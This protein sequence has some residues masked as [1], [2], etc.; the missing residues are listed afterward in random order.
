MYY[1]FGVSD[2]TSRYLAA[3]FGILTVV[4]AMF[5]RPFLGRWGTFLATAMIVFSPSFMYFDR[6]CRED[7]YIAGATFLMA[8]FLFRYYR[9]RQPSDLWWA[10]IGF[11]IAFCTKESM[12]L[13]IAVFGTYLFIRLLPWADVLIAGGLTAFG[14]LTQIIIPKGVEFRLLVF[15]ALIG[16]A[17]GYTLFQL[18]TRWQENLK[19]NKAES[20]LWEII[21]DLGFEKI[22]WSLL[23]WLGWWAV[24]LLIL[25]VGPHFGISFPLPLSFL[26]LLAYL[27][28]VL[29]FCWLWLKNV[30]P[31]LTGSIAI[32]SIIFTLLFTTFFTVGANQPDVWARMH[33]LFNDIYMGA[34]GGLE[35]WWGQHDVHRGDEPWYYYLAQLPANELISFL[36][37]IVAMIYYGLFKRKN[38]PLFLGYWYVGSLAL[39][40][41]AGEK[42]PW[43]I[44]HPLL[45]ALLLSAYFVG[46]I[47]ESAPTAQ[48]W[49]SARLAAILCFG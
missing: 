48:L 42:M 31:A 1:L 15:L 5:L 38:M 28:L 44:L 19:K 47:V 12:F 45:P 11:T 24:A 2:A 16:T 6:F 4:L 25:R 13:T 23:A 21:C 18:F 29:W 36:F 39:F 40:S 33:Q 9:S 8:V 41:W 10:V 37:S 17:L 30:V 46:H 22:S 43:L 14:V 3:F 7:A 20:A 35:Y 34:F 27:G 26:W 49:K 32:S